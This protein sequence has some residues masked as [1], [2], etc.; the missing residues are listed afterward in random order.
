MSEHLHNRKEFFMTDIYTTHYFLGSNSPAGFASLYDQLLNGPSPGMLYVIKGC[1]G[2]GKSG[3]MKKIGQAVSAAGCSTEYIHCSGDPDSLDGVYFPELSVAYVDGTAPHVIEPNFACVTAQ[4]IN[5]GAFCDADRLQEVRQDMVLVNQR[6]KQLYSRAYDLIAA[7]DLADRGYGALQP[8]GGTIAHLEKRCGGI[9]A[10]ELRTYSGHESK[11]TRC[12]LSAF[13]CKGTVCYFDT[14]SQLAD[15][16]YVI[17]DECGFG[18][19]LLER[20]KAAAVEKGY[21]LILCMSPFHPE[22]LEHIILPELS[23]AFVTSKAPCKYQKAPYRHIRL[24]SLLYKNLPGE[25]R[26]KQKAGKKISGAILNDARDTL[27]QAKSLHDELESFYNPAVDFD[28]VYRLADSHI[29][30]LL[31]HPR[32]DNLR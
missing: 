15:R 31:R 11:I 6:Y 18:H 30:A 17:D 29:E 26:A 3:F 5:L 19:Y 23:L 2:G 7:A 28:G 22:V 21:D 1:P 14:V 20:L 10:R 24:D 32:L 12:F 4:Y 8:D 27:A 25:A 9:A 13:T 16:V